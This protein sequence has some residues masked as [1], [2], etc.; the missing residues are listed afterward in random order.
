MRIRV[1]GS[2]EVFDGAIWRA[3]GAAKCRA[4]LASLVAQA[5]DPVHTDQLIDEVWAGAPPKTAPT[6]IHGYVSRLR[7]LLGDAILTR[8]AL[9]YRLVAEPGDVDALAFESWIGSANAALRRGDTDLGTRLLGDALALWRGAPFADAAVTDRV[10]VRV[11]RLTELRLSALESRFDAEIGLG[12]HAAV[13]G[14]LRALVAEHPLREQFWR[15][16][17]VALYHGGRQAEALDEYRRLRSVLVEELGTEPGS[18]VRGVHQQILDGT[19]RPGG[20][21]QLPAVIPDFTG[22]RAVAGA[23]VDRLIS[24][25]GDAPAVVVVHGGPGTGKSTLALRAAHQVAH[26]FPDAHLHLDLA[27]TSGQPRPPAELLAEILRCLGVAG[28]NLPDGV[29]A[30]SALLRSHLADLR[31]LLVLDDASGS[32]QVLPLLPSNGRSAVVVTSRHLLTDLPGARHVEL[33]TLTAAEGYELLARIVGEDRVGAEPE[34]ARAILRYCGNL[35][36]SIRIAGGRLLGRRSWT[37]EV[38]AERLADESQRLAELKL[39]DLDVRASVDLS[40]RSL[41]EDVVRGFGLLGLLGPH[42]FPGW[43]LAALLDRPRADDVLDVLVDANL[44]Q[45]VSTDRAG[46]PRYRLHDLLRVYA[47]ER[48]GESAA[49]LERLL[50]AWLDLLARAQRRR[51]PSMFEPVIGEPPGWRLPDAVAQ[52]LVRDPLAWL[53]AERKLLSGLVRL[54]AGRRPD[55][56][57]ALT[58]ALVPYHDDRAFYDDWLANHDLALRL[59][60]GDLGRAELL[61]G[62]A[63]VQI[64]RGELTEAA[65]NMTRSLVLFRAAGHVLGEGLAASGMATIDRHRGRYDSSLRYVNQSLDIFVRTG[66]RAMEAQLR[67]AAG[68]LLVARGRL[69]DARLWFAQALEIATADGDVHREAV[70]LR[71]LGELRHRAGESHQALRDLD[72]ALGVFTELQDD[73][74]VAYTLLTR[75]QVHADLRDRDRAVPALLRA[76]EM[77]RRNGNVSSEQDCRQLLG[78]LDG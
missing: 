8:S 23:V 46:Q 21:R 45:L 76:A 35:P 39:G 28:Q 70:V 9:G 54:A 27:G 63:H 37:L 51:P 48:A 29:A 62:L 31:T 36:L 40:L 50:G 47:A 72:R 3:I 5:P 77:F 68:R 56:C 18:G 61:R 64:Y 20:V 11:E 7:R 10:R 67:C 57:R 13:I 66:N 71:E 53:D 14:E 74:C 12:R 59:N 75:G 73:R 15:Q 16:L 42:E 69:D 30:R 49:A 32:A 6:Q 34:A 19:L 17:M 78:V 22:R 65:G 26:A 2:M 25:D 41:P 4:V 60:H 38:L 24:A 52:R 1:L 55:L 43:V 44:V 33:G 58:A